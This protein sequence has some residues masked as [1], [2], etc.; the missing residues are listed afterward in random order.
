MWITRNRQTGR[1]HRM[2]LAIEE[3]TKEH[4]NVICISLNRV[5]SIVLAKRFHEIVAGRNK[6]LIITNDNIS[7]KFNDCAIYWKTAKECSIERGNLKYWDR[8]LK[9]SVQFMDHSV[10]EHVYREQLEELHKYDLE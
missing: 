1:T 8:G 4:E 2:L 10:I 6:D 3:A 9:N 7:T 5:Q